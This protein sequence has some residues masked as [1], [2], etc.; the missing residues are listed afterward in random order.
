M[1]LQPSASYSFTMRLHLPRPWWVLMAVY[2]TT[3]PLAGA[4]RPKMTYRLLGIVAGAAAAVVL[5][6]HL[7]N[8][9]PALC[10]AIAAWI[11]LCLY[12]AIQERTPRTF[13]FMLA[14]YTAAIVGFP[15]LDQPGDIFQ[16]ALDRVEEMSLGVICATVAHT[17]FAPWDPTTALRRRIEAFVNS[18][19]ARPYIVASRFPATKSS[20]SRSA[21]NSSLRRFIFHNSRF[22]GSFA[23]QSARSAT[24]WRYAAESNIVRCS[25]FSDQPPSMKLP[26]R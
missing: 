6:P 11:G 13:G 19:S 22:S 12:L 7:V 26:A 23:R 14:A 16:I 9:P 5:V 4:L 1:A 3:Q 18:S 10:L 8:S 15:Y 2:V 20:E 21:S 24:C 25:D 17:V